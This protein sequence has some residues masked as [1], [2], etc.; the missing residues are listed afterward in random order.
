MQHHVQRE[1]SWR[2][3][4]VLSMDGNRI[5]VRGDTE[6][7]KV[8]IAVQGAVGPRR[9]R[10]AVVRDAFR[11][12]HSTIPDLKPEE[13]VPLPDNSAI[14]VP[15]HHLLTLEEAGEKSYFPVGAKKS[16]DVQELLN[17]VDSALYRLRR[18]RRKTK[19]RE[20]ISEKH[21]FVSYCHDDKEEV[22]RLIE[23][24]ENADVAVWWDE[25]ILGGQDWKESIR[26]A[27]KN[28][29]AVVACLS[30]ELEERHRSGAYPE[31]R[32]A[33]AIFRQCA[34]G[35]S[36]IFP[37]RLGDCEIPPIEI[38]DTRTLDRLQYVDL[39]PE[40]KRAQGIRKLLKSLETA[41]T[42]RKATSRARRGTTRGKRTSR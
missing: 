33:I 19:E 25:N 5:L 24:L 30:P 9:E 27:M 14:T 18:S 3:G 4:T 31:I 41:P 2:S 11:Y 20:S 10:L 39:F 32:N 6:K 8:F 26:A 12:I 34:P 42:E 35:H 28:A 38:D 1:K 22:A 17:G 7:G 13:E 21:V 36:F 23:D 16:Y 15:Y 37:V 40:S 29:C